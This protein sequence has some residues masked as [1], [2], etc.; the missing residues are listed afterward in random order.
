VTDCMIVDDDAGAGGLGELSL[1]EGGETTVLATKECQVLAFVHTV[2]GTK[3]PGLEEAV[4][5]TSGCVLCA[6]GK[7]P[8]F[9]LWQPAYDVDFS[10][11]CYLHGVGGSK[12]LAGTN[13]GQDPALRLQG[14]PWGGGLL[15]PMARIVRPVDG[16]V[17]LLIKRKVKF[18]Y[19]VLQTKITADMPLD[20]LAEAVE[21]FKAYGPSLI[22]QVAEPISR[23][24][25]VAIPA[26]A[27]A[28]ERKGLV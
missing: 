13:V 17:A 5:C 11:P 25:L 10:T 20:K 18:D 3:I 23:E 12:V 26:I 28:M 22:T 16:P 19:S 2:K 24:Y 14:D 6:L 4:L 8:F 7:L 9:H 15:K 21:Q 27:H 1:S